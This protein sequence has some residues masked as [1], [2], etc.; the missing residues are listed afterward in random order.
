MSTRA[1]CVSSV[2]VPRVR[3]L[4]VVRGAGTGTT[5]PVAGYLHSSV[6]LSLKLAFNKELTEALCG[7]RSTSPRRACIR[8]YFTRLGFVKGVLTNSSGPLC[9]PSLLA[10][11][12]FSLLLRLRCCVLPPPRFGYA[13]ARPPPRRLLGAALRLRPPTAALSA[14][15]TACGRGPCRVASAPQGGLPVIRAL[16]RHGPPPA[17]GPGGPRSIRLAFFSPCGPCCFSRA[18]CM[19]PA[20]VPLVRI[21]PGSSPPRVLR[22]LSAA[23]A[24]PLS[25]RGCIRFALL[26][27]AWSRRR[28]ASLLRFFFL[29]P[30]GR[31][32][33]GIYIYLLDTLEVIDTACISCYNGGG[34]GAIGTTI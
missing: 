8:F 11:E 33:G 18:S 19:L 34:R 21:V 13:F 10:L 28:P 5:G 27:P 12:C 7:L 20:P 14:P 32:K 24:A 26:P 17:A 6:V 31:Y 15:P 3:C 25:S 30:S 23:V 29:S 4:R 1:A 2:S 22:Q 16:P 9:S